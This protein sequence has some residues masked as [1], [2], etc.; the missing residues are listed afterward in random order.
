MAGKRHLDARPAHRANPALDR[1]QHLVR[2]RAAEAGDPRF[3]DWPGIPD[4]AERRRLVDP[5]ALRVRQDEPHAL[6]NLVM[7]VG[8]HLDLDGL[9]SLARMKGQ[10]AARR[11]IV[12]PGDRLRVEDIA[13]QVVPAVLGPVVD[14]D[15][16][17]GGR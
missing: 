7:V 10:R 17:F 1:V 15:R 4:R 2:D 13:G 14:R 3:R 9:Q 6:V 11:H 16:G 8:Q 5:R 12:R